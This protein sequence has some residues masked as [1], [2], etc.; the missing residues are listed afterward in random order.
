[1]NKAYRLLSVKPKDLVELKG[2]ADTAALAEGT[3]I[4][5]DE[6]AAQ[7]AGSTVGLGFIGYARLRGFTGLHGL[8]DA[9]WQAG[10]ASP[11]DDATRSAPSRRVFSD[12]GEM[13]LPRCRGP[14]TGALP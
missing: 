10:P 6:D 12:R 5:V 14:T 7:E 4:L 2:H 1:I 13:S 8:Y 11:P 9:A 3:R